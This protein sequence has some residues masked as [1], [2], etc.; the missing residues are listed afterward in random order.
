MPDG[1]FAPLLAAL[2]SMEEFQRVAEATL[3]PLWMAAHDEHLARRHAAIH[4][5]SKA[6]VATKITSS[7]E[8]PGRIERTSSCFEA[9]SSSASTAA[10]IAR[11]ASSDSTLEDSFAVETSIRER[12]T[13]EA[14]QG[15]SLSP[16]PTDATS[17]R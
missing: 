12:A 1:T 14:T 11:T 10:S 9:T 16:S 15:Q 4:K 13:L 7:W 5:E 6:P 8:L 17:G 3:S 2:E